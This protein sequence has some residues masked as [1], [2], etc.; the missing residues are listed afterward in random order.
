MT[1]HIVCL[2]NKTGMNHI[3]ELI[4][5]NSWEKVIVITTEEMAGVFNPQNEVNMFIINSA[6]TTKELAADLIQKLKG[7]VNG[8]EVAL[9]LFSGTGK[10]HM[11]ILS[12]LLKIGMG[13]RLVKQGKDGFEEL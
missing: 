7:N 12:A 10:E 2:T 9:N 13:I 4:D 11:A 6:M 5:K 8:M 3:K 1:D